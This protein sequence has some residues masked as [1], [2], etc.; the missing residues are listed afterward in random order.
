MQ[1]YSSTSLHGTN[2]IAHPLESLVILRFPPRRRRSNMLR[3]HPSESLHQHNVRD[4]RGALR[5][6]G[7]T[8][9]PDSEEVVQPDASSD[10]FV[11]VSKKHTHE[12][13]VI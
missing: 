3:E 8:K 10:L 9:L 12:T 11:T 5:Q 4:P 7:D 13:I 6:T 2:I 1:H